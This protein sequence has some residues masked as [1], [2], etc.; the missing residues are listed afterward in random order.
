MDGIQIGNGAVIA[1]GSVVT[2]NVGDYEIVGGV[3]AK[4]IKMRFDNETRNQ[5]LKS[6]W[7]TREAKD[8]IESKFL[9]II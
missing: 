6:K 2:K 1:S 5:L 8:I 7:W 4:L 9:K 3:P